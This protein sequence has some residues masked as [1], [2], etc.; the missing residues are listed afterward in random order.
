VLS[1]L[2]KFKAR[3]QLCMMVLLAGA[4]AM[5]L[6]L[7]PFRWINPD[8]GAH[9]LDASLFLEGYLPIADYGSRQPLY[10]L[11][12]SVPIKLFGHH[13]LTS[14]LVPI[15]ASVGSG[16]IIFLLGKRFFQEKIGLL[17]ALITLYL[18]L[19]F[20]WAPVVKT[21][22]IAIFFCL[23]SVYFLSR[24]FST[25]LVRPGWLILSGI[26][27]AA[28]FY[29]RQ[30]TLYLPITIFIFFVLR[31]DLSRSNA[32]YQ[33]FLF[34]LGYLSICVSFVAVY[35]N[36]ISHSELFFSQL[37]PLNLVWNRLLHLFGSLPEAQQ[38][39]DT[40]GF[41]FL[42]QSMDVTI[43]AWQ[44]SVLFSLFVIV[45]AAS[46]YKAIKAAKEPHQKVAFVFMMS[47]AGFAFALYFYQ[48]LSRGFYTQYFTELLPPLVLLAARFIFP[49]FREIKA[50]TIGLSI[51]S[52]G[53]FYFLYLLQRIFWQ[54]Y[55][56]IGIYLVFGCLFAGI[57]S[58]RIFE[59]D[60]TRVFFIVTLIA[61]FVSG[62]GYRGLVFAGFMELIALL[63]ILAIL[64]LLVRY[65]YVKHLNSLT[66]SQ[67]TF[68]AGAFIVMTAFVVT[69]LYS[70]HLVGPRYESI[71][72]LDSLQKTVRVLKKSGDMNDDILSGGMIWTFESGFKPFMN[73]THPTE[74]LK[75]YN[76]EFQ[77][78]FIKHRPRFIIKDGYTH[79]KYQRY[80]T[81]ING[82]I[83]E[84]Y[85][86]LATIEGSFYPIEIYQRIDRAMDFDIQLSM[87][88]RSHSL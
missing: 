87:L 45:A 23:M 60:K 70:G 63:G 26:F 69:A 35:W 31:R 20:I 61:G 10:V 2:E 37:N 53:L 75:I 17:A 50:N 52:M 74:F 81:F 49:S 32:F 59:R 44:D 78:S 40:E 12:L 79:R 38:I 57:V 84:H 72:S 73:V 51:L 46:S 86:H 36:R 42:G 68:H 22:P 3:P 6:L 16:W 48:S 47:W 58:W 71:W 29:V 80:W 39:T 83:H 33:L 64:Y 65:L 62:F 28:A 56:G 7:L 27:A 25:V 30:P 43:T 9:L 11:L 41:R 18:P 24:T 15:L 1:W 13:V 88:T 66:F 82:Q 21:E 54:I 14:R 4:L 77:N 76:Q 34:I 5:R 8:E 19:V 55:P 85:R 67:V